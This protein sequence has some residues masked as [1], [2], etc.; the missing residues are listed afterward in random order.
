VVRPDDEAAAGEQRQ[1][2]QP[3]DAADHDQHDRP[4]PRTPPSLV[5]GHR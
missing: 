4:E 3:G 1:P 2:D 5:D